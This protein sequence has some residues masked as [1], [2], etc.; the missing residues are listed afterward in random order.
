MTRFLIL[1]NSHIASLKGAEAAF[2]KENPNIEL[3]F[4][5]VGEPN[6]SRGKIDKQGIY[7]TLQK[8]KGPNFGEKISVDTK[9]FDKVFVVG[10]YTPL[11]VLHEVLVDHQLLE[12]RFRQEARLVSTSFLKTVIEHIVQHTVS[13]WLKIVG[14]NF[15]GVI[16]PIP[17][18]NQNIVTTQ[19]RVKHRNKIY[20]DLNRNLDSELIFDLWRAEIERQMSKTEASLLMQPEETIYAPFLTKNIYST[21]DNIHTTDDFALLLL[22]AFCSQLTSRENPVD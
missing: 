4:F 17:F 15:S 18:P 16:S 6:F 19:K 22:R 9:E 14:T 10:L 2:T 11:S 13:R 20:R 21:A 7:S 8:A 12:G 5:G 1:G 3:T